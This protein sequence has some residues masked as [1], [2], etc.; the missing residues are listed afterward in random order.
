[1]VFVLEASGDPR[2]QKLQM[3]VKPLCLSVFF[4][5]ST[6]SVREGRKPVYDWHFLQGLELVLS[7]LGSKPPA[8]C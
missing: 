3:K 5:E 1:M 2:R 4:P 7:L 8:V 6:F